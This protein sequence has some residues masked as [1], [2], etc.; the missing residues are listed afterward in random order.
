M[1][2]TDT[3]E[4][5]AIGNGFQI[6]SCYGLSK[7]IDAYSRPAVRSVIQQHP[8]QLL[9]KPVEITSNLKTLRC[10]VPHDEHTEMGPEG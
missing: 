9:V 5:A 1:L 7:C 8:S 10:G 2:H 6:Y 4:V 3:A